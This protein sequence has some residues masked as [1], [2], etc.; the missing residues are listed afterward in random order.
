VTQIIAVLNAIQGS[1]AWDNAAAC[2]WWEVN[3]ARI[4]AL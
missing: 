2:Q 3:A 4:Q 1:D